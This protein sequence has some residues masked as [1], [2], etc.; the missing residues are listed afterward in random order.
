MHSA[1]LVI[2]EC[3]VCVVYEHVPG[4]GGGHA[5]RVGVQV[6]EVERRVA[7]LLPHL[8]QIGCIRHRTL[9]RNSGERQILRWEMF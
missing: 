7:S 6:V 2:S 5:E 9:G 4:L 1:H 8:K 3:H